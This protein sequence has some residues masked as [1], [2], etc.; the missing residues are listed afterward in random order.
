M[1]QRQYLRQK[2]VLSRQWLA[3]QAVIRRLIQGGQATPEH[4]GVVYEVLD[5]IER[6]IQDLDAACASQ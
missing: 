1:D 2:A 3:T 6:A 5:A 4:L